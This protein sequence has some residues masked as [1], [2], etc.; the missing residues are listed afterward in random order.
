MMAV[1]YYIIGKIQKAHPP[2][3]KDNIVEYVKKA[4]EAFGHEI[5]AIVE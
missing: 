1:S 3:F 5:K 4:S 2:Y